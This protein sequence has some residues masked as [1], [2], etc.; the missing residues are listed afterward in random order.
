M[1]SSAVCTWVWVPANIDANEVLEMVRAAA[2]ELLVR[3]S[4]FDRFQKN[5]RV[6]LAYRLVFQSFDRTLEDKDANDAMEHVYAA[7][8][9]REFEIR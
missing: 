5:D 9:E 2:G 8:R 1:R 7:L 6:S 3:I 4:Q